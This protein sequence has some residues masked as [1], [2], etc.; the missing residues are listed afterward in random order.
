MTADQQHTAWSL[1]V[2][3]RN[4]TETIARL[5]EVSETEQTEVLKRLLDASVAAYSAAHLLAGTPLE[6]ERVGR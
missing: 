3:R 2:V 4:L 1:V 6:E 5:A